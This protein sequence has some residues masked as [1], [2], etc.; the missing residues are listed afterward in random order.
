MVCHQLC[1]QKLPGPWLLR[2]TTP[3]PYSGSTEGTHGSHLPHVR[4]DPD[5]AFQ[6]FGA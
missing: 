3:T 5:L 6:N 4:P 1:E 2:A